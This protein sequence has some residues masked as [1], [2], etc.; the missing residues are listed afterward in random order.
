MIQGFAL[1]AKAGKSCSRVTPLCDNSLVDDITRRIRRVTEDLQVIQEE[2]GSAAVV[3]P[4]GEPARLLDEL[5][6]KDLIN[7]FKSAVDHMRQFL[8][9]YIDAVCRKEGRNVDYTLQAF[10]MQRVTEML[11]ILRERV[12]LPQIMKLPEA[13]SFFEE[14]QATADTVVE[15]HYPGSQAADK[16]APTLVKG[17]RRAKPAS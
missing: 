15:R 11:R 4:G 13:H 3:E 7:D 8:W 9:S 1:P 5:L 14:I 10:R 6:E 2:L 17:S 12:E 16:P